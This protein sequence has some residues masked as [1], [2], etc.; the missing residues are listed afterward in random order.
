METI[1]YKGGSIFKYLAELFEA[2]G[3]LPVLVG[4]YAINAYHI[5]RMTFDI[6]F[7]LTIE[8]FNK[9]KTDLFESG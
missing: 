4:G 1:K 2:R 9:I 8:E 7:I 3:V 5:Q 6:D